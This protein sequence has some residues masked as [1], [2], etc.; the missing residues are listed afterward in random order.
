MTSV[1]PSGARRLV[2]ATL[3]LPGL[4]YAA[5]TLFWQSRGAYPLAGDE[6]HYLILA[7]AMASGHLDL[8]EAYVA[9]LR[10][11][12]RPNKHTVARGSHLYSHHGLGLPLL[13]AIP[14]R[15]GGATGAK[16]ALCL[17]AGGLI[18]AIFR[19]FFL[20]T[21]SR[22]WS[23]AAFLVIAFA[24]PNTMAAGQIY[25]D[26]LVGLIDVCL[27]SSILRGW[28]PGD[29]PSSR[30]LFAAACGLLPW[31]H[32]R[33]FPVAALFTVA[34]AV[35]MVL[36]ERARRDEAGESSQAPR[37]RWARLLAPLAL[38]V[39]LQLLEIAYTL[40]L[41]GSLTGVRTPQSQGL[42]SVMLLFGLHLDQFHGLFL[43]NPLLLL[44]LAGLAIFAFERPAIF[45][46][47]VAVYA[48]SALPVILV[49]DS[50]YGGPTF[51]GRYDWD[52]AA[53]WIFPL[54]HLLAWALRQ[55]G[56]K[57][58]VALVLAATASV[59]V[60]CAWY[61]A[62]GAIPLITVW[63]RP[64]WAM[65]TFYPG[66]RRYLPWFGRP[67]QMLDFWPNYSWTIFALVLILVGVRLARRRKPG[68]GVFALLLPA[69]GLVAIPQPTDRSPLTFAGRAFFKTTGSD[70][71]QLRVAHGGK[72]GAGVLAYGP[73]VNLPPGCYEVGLSYRAVY[74]ND[75]EPSR[76]DWAVKDGAIVLA[77]GDLDT[78]PAG[79]LV[80]NE[81]L[82]PPGGYLSRFEVRVWYPGTGDVAVEKL[83]ITPRA[84]CD[85]AVRA[86]R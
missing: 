3:C 10:N 50:G 83:T 76:W 40:W 13:I 22:R 1:R 9:E 72:D 38:A 36:E 14:N 33:H 59:Q 30:F 58:A 44:G 52:F 67:A 16:I 51:P 71:D 4:V 86:P 63:D 35:R 81:L 48:G 74:A 15:I 45:S 28:A 25:P 49:G 43:Q 21:G 55:R 65:A 73:Y 12:L 56:G 19:V 8:R 60:A 69:A 79:K 46:L 53:L 23:L 7:E 32:H 54:A 39:I 62:R 17:V 24:L 61:W 66:L 78:A 5:V 82:V 42:A 41:F 57:T 47:W 27:L 31:L 6:P 64:V 85:G 68:F 26:L 77:A 29:P 37:F 84:R 80:A 34:F 70:E 11:G 75:G 20:I 2:I 18:T